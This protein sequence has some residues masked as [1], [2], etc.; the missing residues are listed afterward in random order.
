MYFRGSNSYSYWIRNF[1]IRLRVFLY[2]WQS[3]SWVS[4]RVRMW[5]FRR[6]QGRRR[7]RLTPLG[8]CTRI[9]TTTGKRFSRR[10]WVFRL[11]IWCCWF[12]Y[13]SSTEPLRCFV[14]CKSEYFALRSS[15][16]VKCAAHHL[17]RETLGKMTSL[18]YHS[19]RKIL[20]V[21]LNDDAC[22]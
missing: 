16:I 8:A 6:L 3:W 9:C 21:S 19:G 17:M 12:D 11:P 10:N 5:G 13:L 18:C 15:E 4:V 20:L 1:L 22:V 7:V 2:W 14:T